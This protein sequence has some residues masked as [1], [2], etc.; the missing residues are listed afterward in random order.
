KSLATR[1]QMLWTRIWRMCRLGSALCLSSHRERTLPV[2]PGFWSPKEAARYLN[3]HVR[4]VYQWVAPQQSE[5]ARR[6]PIDSPPPPFA[7]LGRRCIRFP[8]KEFRQW[9]NHFVT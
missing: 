1:A 9:A 7:K 2:E 8:I 4:T 5:K 6:T 3:A